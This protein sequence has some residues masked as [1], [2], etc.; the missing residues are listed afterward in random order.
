MDAIALCVIPRCCN[1]ITLF[2]RACVLKEAVQAGHLWG[3]LRFH[4]AYLTHF[5]KI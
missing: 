3:L 2:T 5:V 4:G 1:A